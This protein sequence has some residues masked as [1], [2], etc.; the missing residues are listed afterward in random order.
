VPGGAGARL[1][2]AKRRLVHRQGGRL[3]Q[4]GGHELAEAGSIERLDQLE[5]QRRAV[6][7]EHARALPYPPTL[8][9]VER[10]V[11]LEL[12]VDRVLDRAAVL[13]RV[14]VREGLVDPLGQPQR[15]LG[16]DGA[17]DQETAVP[18]HARAQQPGRQLGG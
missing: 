4:V 18:E 1:R 3:P 10:R 2:L 6:R 5:H 14:A 11:G 8:G 15:L 9:E 16:F 13:D 7:S 12:L 17:A